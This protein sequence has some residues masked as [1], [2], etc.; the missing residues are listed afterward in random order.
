[1]A[2]AQRILI[3]SQT[4]PPYSGIGG[5]RWAKFTKY[6]S[7]A[8]NDVRVICADLN[9]EKNSPWTS[10]VATVPLRTYK[11]SFP[12]V[13]EQFPKNI[14]ERVIYRLQL[15]KLKMISQGT[16][17]DR[18]LLDEASFKDILLKELKDFRPDFTIVTAPMR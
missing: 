15:A 5:R 17:Y 6:L 16:P 2:S 4:F 7:S 9:V 14:F 18:A 13:V 12:K 1:M 10:D 11:H 3:V 8:E